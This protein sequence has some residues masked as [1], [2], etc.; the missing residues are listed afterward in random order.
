MAELKR[1]FRPEFL[2]RL[3]AVVV[4]HSLSQEHIRQI[5]DLMIKEIQERLH[6]QRLTL[7]TTEAAKDLLVEK[8]FDSLNGAR[9]CAESFRA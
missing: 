3:D 7:Q 8:G 1:T 2:N 5:V 4:F 6:E 9:A